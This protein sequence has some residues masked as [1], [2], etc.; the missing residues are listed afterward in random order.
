MEHVANFDPWVLSHNLHFLANYQRNEKELLISQTSMVTFLPSSA[1]KSH[2]SFSNCP[3]TVPENKHFGALKLSDGFKTNKKLNELNTEDVKQVLHLTHYS[4]WPDSTACKIN[5]NYQ[6]QQ[7]W[8]W[9]LRSRNAATTD[10]DSVHVLLQHYVQCTGHT[11]HIC[12]YACI[13]RYVQ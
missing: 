6:Q 11:S 12:M 3:H 10:N 9:K 5:C 2:H 4:H 1:V 13:Y 8:F 7:A